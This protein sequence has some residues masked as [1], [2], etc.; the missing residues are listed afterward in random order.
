[1]GCAD[2]RSRQTERH[3]GDATGR[4][5]P[6]VP[7]LRHSWV[8]SFPHSF[9]IRTFRREKDERGRMRVAFQLDP[10]PRCRRRVV[11]LRCELGEGKRGGVTWGSPA[12]EGPEPSSRGNRALGAGPGLQPRKVGR[13]LHPAPVGPG[14]TWR[15][16]RNADCALRLRTS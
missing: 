12:R 2:G 10:E 5:R 16:R 14:P 4:G 7:L 6:R 3:W 9:S 8:H 15:T 1:M 11:G 13:L